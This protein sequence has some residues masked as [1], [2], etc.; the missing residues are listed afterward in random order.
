LVEHYGDKA[1]SYLDVSDWVRQF[2]M[3][4]EGVEDWRR[5]RRLLDFQTHFRIERALGASPNASIRD[6]AQT[7]S[8][9]PSTVFCVLTQVHHLECGKWRW[10][11]QIE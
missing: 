1:L 11:P 7:T 9:A 6:I 2:H 8:I 5:S 3:R 10:P 4:R